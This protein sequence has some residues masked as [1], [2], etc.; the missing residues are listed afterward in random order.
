MKLFWCKTLFVC[1]FVVPRVLNSVVIPFHSAKRLVNNFIKQI[2]S[3]Y[4]FCMCWLCRQLIIDNIGL[5]LNSNSTFCIM[6]YKM[7]YWQWNLGGKTWIKS[8]EVFYIMSQCYY[9]FVSWDLLSLHADSQSY[10]NSIYGNY[11]FN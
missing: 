1:F 9:K 3:T 11:Y 2:H 5:S 10:T 8:L 4:L 7:F 6:L